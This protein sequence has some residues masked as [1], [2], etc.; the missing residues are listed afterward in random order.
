VTAFRRFDPATRA[1]LEAADFAICVL[2][3]IDFLVSL[4][5]APRKVRY[6]VTWGWLDLLS[7]VPAVSILRLGR[8]ARIVRLL[9]LLRGLRSTRTLAQF[10]IEHR[11]QSAL[12]AALLLTVLLLVMGSITILHVE[13]HPDSNI[14]GPADALWW[15]LVTLTTVGYGDR[16]P[17]TAEGRVVA[18]ILMLCGVGL[19]GIL[20]G[21]LASWFLAPGEREQ[22]DELAELRRE[23]REIRTLL[24]AT[25]PG[26]GA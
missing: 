22:E 24:Q 8:F 26:P 5:R 10:L 12:L 7:S 2:F 16:Y 23:I 17:V 3:L 21:F 25:R 1:I 6:L 4:I 15:S 13:T 19:I 14:R 9:R 20:T 11:A 18:A